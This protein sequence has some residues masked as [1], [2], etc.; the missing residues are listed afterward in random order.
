MDKLDCSIVQKA[1]QLMREVAPGLSGEIAEPFRSRSE[2]YARVPGSFDSA[3]LPDL[4]TTLG[5]PDVDTLARLL[6][7]DAEIFRYAAEGLPKEMRKGDPAVPIVKSGL[8]A[9]VADLHK[10]DEWR[11][12]GSQLF[13]LGHSWGFGKYPSASETELR[14]P[15]KFNRHEVPELRCDRGILSD[16]FAELDYGLPRFAEDRHDR[17]LRAVV[18]KITTYEHGYNKRNRGSSSPLD[19]LS[20][21]QRALYC[22]YW[23]VR[24]VGNGGLMQFFHNSTGAYAKETIEGLDLIKAK[25]ASTALKKACGVFPGGMPSKDY[26]SRNAFLEAMPDKPW[27]L[28]DRLS[29]KL[30]QLG[31]DEIFPKAVAYL[32]AHLDEFFLPE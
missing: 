8:N 14:T 22:I 11:R 16:L 19:A 1:S 20:P 13:H 5:L 30:C 6:M 7:E 21:G 4:A 27:H 9:A 2:L 28:V 26:P 32:K 10:N 29:R 12:C 24:E 23:C 17:L 25:R 31:G 15:K 18:S 3:T